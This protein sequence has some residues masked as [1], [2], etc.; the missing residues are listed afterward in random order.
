MGKEASRA[1]IYARISEAD[2]AVPKVK[3]QESRC[4]R[5][6]ADA[7][8][9]VVRVY[10][11]DGISAFTG[12]HRPGYEQMKLDVA[13]GMI[14]V[15]V[16]TAQDRLSRVPLDLLALQTLCNE[17]DVR[18]HTIHDG[19][20]DHSDS[21]A[22]LRAFMSGYMN[23]HEIKERQRRQRAANEART[24]EGRPLAGGRMFGFEPGGI[25]HR[26]AEAKIIMWACEQIVAGASIYSIVQ[27]LNQS[28]IKTSR[29]KDF[30]YAGL[31]AVLERPRNAGL[32]DRY[33]EVRRDV[34]A[35]W[36]AIVPQGLWEQVCAIL[37]DPER[38]LTLQREPRWLCAG[39][40][41]CGVCG[42]VMRSASATS[43]GE[44][45]PNYR[46]D[47]KRIPTESNRGRHVAIR[48]AVLDQMV[49]DAVVS[50][51]LVS[52]TD[53]ASSQI[54]PPEVGTLRSRLAE[55]HRAQNELVDLVDTPHFKRSMVTRKAAEL[56]VEERALMSRLNAIERESAQAAMFVEAQRGL[57]T[58]P[59][60]IADVAT[61][62]V[63]LG[64]RFDALTL[65]QRRALV[66]ERLSVTILPGRGGGRIQIEHL[67][68][69]SLNDQDFADE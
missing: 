68:T 54:T 60:D 18:W 21:T 12:K 26:P 9:E 6:C 27:H 10:A 32:V 67:W 22:E 39:L 47:S 23:Q 53:D 37:S 38:R 44:K 59:T 45:H 65:A 31:Q 64:E 48:C 5:L 3:I 19:V 2:D 8:Y 66:R 62:K 63:A 11:D 36:E 42:S 16:A 1:G 15:I 29:N 69:Q 50:A 24:E 34:V 52:P 30:T 33:G 56:D 55:I 4:R 25:T 57:W 14:D 43:R 51:Y 17:H 13:A 7:G 58:G 46:C 49:R 40:A 20:L 28:G 41:R 61:V 35:Q